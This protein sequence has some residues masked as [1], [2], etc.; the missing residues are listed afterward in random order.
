MGVRALR[1]EEER[2][3][4]ERLF[5]ALGARARRREADLLEAERLDERRRAFGALGTLARRAAR[6]LEERRLLDLGV[7]ARRE[8]LLV[9]RLEERRF[10]DLGA[11]ALRRAPRLPLRERLFLIEASLS[12]VTLLFGALGVRARRADLLAER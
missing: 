3:L 12:E 10:E 8:D 11:R 1:R 7:R 5:E 2:R 4:A 9:E 6:L